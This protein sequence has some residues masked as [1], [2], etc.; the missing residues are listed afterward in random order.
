MSILMTLSLYS[1][2]GKLLTFISL[3][4]FRPEILL[5]CL[6]HIAL[7]SVCLYEIKCLPGV[8]LGG[9]SPMQCVCP[10]ALVGELDTK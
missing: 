6:E 8:S 10:V 5:F 4:F 1:L 7:N 3:V 9:S 2:S